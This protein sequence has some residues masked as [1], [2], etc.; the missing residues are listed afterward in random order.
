MGDVSGSDAPPFMGR[1]H[2]TMGRSLVNRMYTSM[3]Q[4]PILKMRSERQQL[5]LLMSQPFAR[6]PNYE[7]T[8]QAFDL[9]V[10]GLHA[11]KVMGCL[12]AMEAGCVHLP[13]GVGGKCHHQFPRF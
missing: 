11:S 13:V 12:A 10:Q 7:Q 2:A 8:M 5:A 1:H 4:L 6:Q 3:V 9:F